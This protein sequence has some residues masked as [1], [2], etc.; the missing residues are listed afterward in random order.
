MPTPPSSPPPT[1]PERNGRTPPLAAWCAAILASVLL[2]AIYRA[3]PANDPWYVM[4]DMDLVTTVDMLLLGDGEIPDNVTHPAA[5]MYILLAAARRAA[6]TVRPFS[7]VGLSELSGAMNPAACVAEAAD[8]FRALSPAVQFGTVLLLAAGLVR[9]LGLGPWAAVGVLVLLGAQPSLL[10]HAAMIRAEAYGILYWAAAV[11]AL[12][13][14]ARA[15]TPGGR[16]GTWLLAGALLALALLSKV[17]LLLLVGGLSLLAPLLPRLAPGNAAGPDPDADA[18]PPAPWLA[19]LA[20]ANLLAGGLL[21]LL[22]L[23]VTHPP[24]FWTLQGA[25]GLTPQALG[26]GAFLLLL[27]LGA[28]VPGARR[29]FAEPL[30][31]WTLLV[32]GGLLALL[33]FFPLYADPATAGAHALRVLDM[34]FLRT[35]ARDADLARLLWRAKTTVAFRPLLVATHAALALGLTAGILTRAVRLPRRAWW[36]PLAISALLGLHLLLA[37]RPIL[38]DLLLV[39][40]PLVATSLVYALL[41]LRRTRGRPLLLG[42]AVLS[43]LLALGIV[44]AAHAVRMPMRL[45]AETHRFGWNERFALRWPVDRGRQLR[46]REIMSAYVAAIPAARRGVPD[47]GSG[48]A[49]PAALVRQAARRHAEI[50]RR[51]R[52]VLPATRPTHRRMAPLAPGL[53]VETGPAPLRLRSAPGDRAGAVVVD[54]TDAPLR[55][56]PRYEPALVAEPD[57]SL[58]KTTRDGDRARIPVLPRTGL[59]VYACVRE[60]GADRI[61]QILDGTG[62]GAERARP[63]EAPARLVVGRS[64]D[65]AKEGEGEEERVLSLLRIPEYAELPPEAFAGGGFL[66]IDGE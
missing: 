53:P 24:Q 19:P 6:E 57:W 7:A 54:V 28:T 16:T 50:R 59:A 20:W 63:D 4:P 40:L 58:E 65:D 5:G 49:D 23:R 30:C 21:L 42:A 31:A 38:R 12:A 39:E 32:T 13:A 22:A 55:P 45:D 33:L 51:A 11:A 41:L 1:P 37:T 26:A 2:L 8:F 36:I 9:L 14:A 56:E 47:S 61:R 66:L 64:A 25:R 43:L 46:Y 60:E 3:V 44:S 10:Y 18:E 48:A 27:A 29:R 17:Q 35:I 15:T 34:T 62:G 52:L